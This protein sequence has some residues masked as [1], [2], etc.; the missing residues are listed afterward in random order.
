MGQKRQEN[1]Y[2]SGLF[3]QNARTLYHHGRQCLF[4]ANTHP[5]YYWAPVKAASI[6]E[7]ETEVLKI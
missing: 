7:M 2:K 4:V 3:R 6:S 1:E 5:K